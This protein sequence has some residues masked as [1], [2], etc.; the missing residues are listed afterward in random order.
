M[1]I[2]KKLCMAAVCSLIGAAPAF[3]AECAYPKKPVDPPNGTKAT[4]DEMVAAMKAT[5]QF[6]ADVKDYQACLDTETEGML[7][8]LGN[9]AT[10][11]DIKRV[12]DKQSLKAN[13]AYEEAAKVAEAFNVQLRA[14]KAK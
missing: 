1:T 9:Q 10:A 11:E 4:Q 3:A 6:D 7:N 12:K 14:Y 8:E 13:A 2:K 5:R